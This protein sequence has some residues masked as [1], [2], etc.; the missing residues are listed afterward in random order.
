MDAL[1]AKSE[2]LGRLLDTA[3]LRHQ[4][5]AQNVANVNTPGYHR[6]EV[7]FEDE[8]GRLLQTGADHGKPGQAHPQVVEATG[9]TMRADGNNVDIDNEMGDL[10]KNFM[11]FNVFSQII[12]SRIAQHRS[13]IAGR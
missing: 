9:G 4:V 12:S 1:L 13:A 10:D 2:F 11:L 7:T 3:V 6:L 8:L 5:I